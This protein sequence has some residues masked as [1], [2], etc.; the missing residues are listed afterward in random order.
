MKSVQF[1]FCLHAFI[2]ISSATIAGMTGLIKFSFFFI[3]NGYINKCICIQNAYKY[4]A[5]SEGA[6]SLATY[7]LLIEL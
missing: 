1:C 3:L 7:V 4:I 2:E 6:M 5:E